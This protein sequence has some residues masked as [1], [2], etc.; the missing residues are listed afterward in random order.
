ML[1][2]KNIRIYTIPKKILYQLKFLKL[3]PIIKV[4]TAILTRKEGLLNTNAY[5]SKFEKGKLTVRLG[6]KAMGLQRRMPG[7]PIC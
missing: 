7:C 3:L 5:D 6:C 4:S 1:M 2:C